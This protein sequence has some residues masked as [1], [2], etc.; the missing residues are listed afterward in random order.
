VHGSIDFAGVLK[1]IKEIILFNIKQLL[2]NYNKKL[3]H[4][5]QC[6]KKF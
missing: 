6:C 1:N 2:N 5:E 4:D 3:K